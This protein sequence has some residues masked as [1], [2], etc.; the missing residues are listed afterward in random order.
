LGDDNGG[1]NDNSRGHRFNSAEEFRANQWDINVATALGKLDK[2]VEALSEAVKEGNRALERHVGEQKLEGEVLKSQMQNELK[3][4]RG[5]V[6]KLEDIQK[7]EVAEREQI[8]RWARVLHILFGG[9]VTTLLYWLFSWFESI[10][11]LVKASRPQ[12]LA[13][14]LL[15]A[16]ALSMGGC[17]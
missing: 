12:A 16:W 14:F 2:S 1:F 4:I 7:R 10:A 11:T 6:S 3:D 9:V 17:L 13:F 5:R 15:G 8:G